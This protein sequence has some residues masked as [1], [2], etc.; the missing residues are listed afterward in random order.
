[1]LTKIKKMFVLVMF[2]AF[3]FVLV[4]CGGGISGALEKLVVASEVTED[5]TLPS[6][7]L[8]GAVTTWTSSDE[9]VIKLDGTYAEVF[10]PSGEDKKVTLTAT[11]TLGEKTENKEFVVNVKSYLAPDKIS[12]KKGNL[13]YDEAEK[14]YILIKG[15]PVQLE[16]EVADPEMSTE[17]KWYVSAPTRATIDENN[18]LLGKDYGKVTISATSTSVGANGAPAKDTFD[19]VILEHSNPNQVLLNNRKEIESKI[20]EFISSDY[21]FPAAPNPDVE[22]YYYDSNGEEIW[23]EERGQYVYVEGVD[24]QETIYCTLRYK[25]EET[26]FAFPIR[27]VANE[28][29]NEFKALDYAEKQLNEIFKDYVKTTDKQKYAK[30]TEVP[31]GFTAEEAMYDVSISYDT[32]SDYPTTPIKVQTVDDKLVAKYIKPNDDSS[33]R[34]EVYLKAEYVDRVVRYNVIAAGYTK[35]EIVE[36]IQ[37]NVLPKGEDGGKVTLTCSHIILPTNDTTSKFGNLTIEWVSS[38]ETLLTAN[39][40]FA[41]PD[42]QGE[43]E[44]TLTANIKYGGTVGELYAFEQSVNVPVTVKQAENQAQAIALQISNHI[45]KEEFMSK[46]AYFPFG[47]P[48]REGGNVLPLPTKV[49]ELTSEMAEYADLEI[50]WTAKEEGLLS[51][52]NKFL[53]QYLRYHEAILVYSIEF[54]GNIATGEVVINVGIGKTKDTIYVGGFFS[55]DQTDTGIHAGDVLSQL[56]KFDAPVGNP[57]GRGKQ[58]SAAYG[59]AMFGGYVLTLQ[60]EEKDEAGNVISSTPYMLFI[61]IGIIVEVNEEFELAA[62]G[63]TVSISK[64]TEKYGGGT[65]NWGNFFVNTT[66][67]DV[68]VP[69]SPAPNLGVKPFVDAEGAEEGWPA[70]S[71]QGRDNSMAFDGYRNGFVLDAEGKVVFGNGEGVIQDI[72]AKNTDSSDMENFWITIP[73]GG[74]AMSFKSQNNNPKV[75]GKFCVVDAQMTVDYFEPYYTSADGSNGADEDLYKNLWD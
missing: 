31:A 4:G 10:R 30:D 73:A 33:V 45:E 25:G 63:S 32:I 67:E 44:V 7:T 55:T 49:S 74:C 12:I 65:N 36:Y 71:T 72:C 57:S 8:E 29:K 38:D 19:V 53:K 20:P 18:V 28:E 9:S 48:G 64:F 2:A 22:T 24:R 26:E 43:K 35:E 46:I 62:D 16:I 34:I 6:V 41:N 56:S 21:Q 13:K 47:V 42:L 15:E 5:F 52:E 14:A 23:G 3:A 61:Q 58:Y 37:T 66:N 70:L 59:H 50:K 60:Y 39:G 68:K 75:S 54:D 27:V 51:A 40:K 69:M 11:V 1:M 17:V